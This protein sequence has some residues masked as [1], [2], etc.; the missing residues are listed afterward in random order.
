MA[1]TYRRKKT[2]RDAWLPV[3]ITD[4]GKVQLKTYHGSAHINALCDASGF[5]VVPQGVAEIERETI[6]KIR[7]LP[8]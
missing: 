1:E 8:T 6:V 2:D 3:A 5:L 4:D 7:M